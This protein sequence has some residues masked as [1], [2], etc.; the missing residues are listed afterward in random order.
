[1][2]RYA[3]SRGSRRPS[4]FSNSPSSFDVPDHWEGTFDLVERVVLQDDQIRAAMTTAVSHFITDLEA[5]PG[6]DGRTTADREE[7][8]MIELLRD[9]LGF[10]EFVLRAGLDLMSYG[11][12][13]G[14]LVKPIERRLACATKGCGRS[15]SLGRAFSDGVV[16]LEVRDFRFHGTCPTCRRRGEMIRRDQ[17]PKSENDLQLAWRRPQEMEVLHSPFGGRDRHIWKVS[18]E[19]RRLL[20]EHHKRADAVPERHLAHVEWGVVEAVRRKSKGVLLPERD[21]YHL[22]MASLSGVRA[23]SL[24]V[25]P[26]LSSMNSAWLVR[27]LA[28]QTEHVLQD[29]TL[30][31][32]ILTPARG[33]KIGQEMDMMNEITG[34]GDAANFARII[35]EQRRDPSAIH[36]HPRPVQYQALGADA[37]N[38]VPVEL[39]N[40][41]REQLLN[42]MGI[43]VEMHKG[44]LSL[45][46]GGIGLRIFESHHSPLRKQLN[47][48]TAQICRDVCEFLG[49]EPV[50]LKWTR[51]TDYDDPNMKLA[52]MQYGAEGHASMRTAMRSVGLD[53]RLEQQRMVEDEIYTANLQMQAK[54][55]LEKLGLGKMMAEPRPE[56]GPPGEGG[57]PAGPGGPPPGPAGPGGPPPGDPWAAI[58]PLLPGQHDQLTPTELMERANQVA[59]VVNGLP[60]P[61]RQSTLI[62]ISKEAAGIHPHVSQ[63]LEQQRNQERAQAQAM[64]RQ[65]NG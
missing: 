1:M 35:A 12:F 20:K 51:P 41:A 19:D 4:P 29:F 54:E 34:Q 55:R 26:V 22:R 42:G 10:D 47:R 53:H 15:M 31:F 17:R 58:K 23:R 27:L 44:T 32:R 18:E 21:N 25:P 59:Q 30:P 49:R 48:L 40:W 46:Q 24:G 28:R 33:G 2:T 7:R 11:N 14:H 38:L 16:D 36:Y 60:E 57:G 62:R 37:K 6:S 64:I 50:I 45:Q 65:Q 9:T 8:W 3:P 43:P 63:A 5:A 13:W 56:E 61:V 52:K 39:L